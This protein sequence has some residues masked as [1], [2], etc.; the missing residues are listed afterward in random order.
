MACEYNPFYIDKRVLV[1][2][3]T[4]IL[5]LHNF[6]E[7]GLLPKGGEEDEVLVKCSS[8]DYNTRW[9]DIN[10]LISTSLTFQNA[11]TPTGNVI[12]WEG[13]L[14]KDTVIS[15]ASNTY[16]INF[17]ELS[18]FNVDALS[19]TISG[20]NFLNVR[21]PDFNNINREFGLLQNL[22]TATGETEYT[23]YGFPTTAGTENQILVMNS[24]GDLE[25]RDNLLQVDNTVFVMKNGNDSTAQRE[26]FDLPFL[27]VEAAVAAANNGDTVIVYP[28]QYTEA[29]GATIMKPFISMELRPQAEIIVNE[30]TLTTFTMAGPDVSIIGAGKITMSAK[31]SYINV[32]TAAG[33]GGKITIDIDQ[34][35]L[36]GVSLNFGDYENVDIKLNELNV[37]D[38]SGLLFDGAV[39]DLSAK[40]RVNKFVTNINIITTVPIIIADQFNI[41]SSFDIEINKVECINLDGPSGFLRTVANEDTTK[42]KLHINEFLFTNPASI[43]D[44]QA[45][46]YRNGACFAQKDISIKGIRHT[47]YLS[48][49]ITLNG[50]IAEQG[51]ITFEG[52]H[53]DNAVGY[54]SFDILNLLKEDEEIHYH[55]NIHDISNTYGIA[56]NF[57]TMIN[58]ASTTGKQ[59]ISGYFK[60]DK[61][62][63][64]A[65]NPLAAIGY[66]GTNGSPI[67]TSATID[68]FTVVCGAGYPSFRRTSNDAGLSAPG[69]GI[70]NRHSM[71]NEAVD[72]V[73]SGPVF[74]IV[75]TLII[76][77]AVI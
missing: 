66:G 20:T 72:P 58:L 6:L 62:G 34:L 5:N 27:T 50:G 11:L 73:N 10:N 55:L 37:T 65:F 24:T 31:P 67:L 1:N 2:G 61:A 32:P 38:A 69:V 77:P 45:P 46:I 71:T 30:A 23:P 4:S 59:K 57:G 40:V 70:P 56:A 44:A 52:L 35:F 64:P 54:G 60:T 26:R 48:K 16:L 14:I 12:T 74:L 41:P 75:P 7:L 39:L 3:R 43:N 25:F 17:E 9:E 19:T 15:G 28:G 18:L 21:T 49:P 13:P 36:D 68:N 8:R 29:N 42:I 22:D 51:T 33:F 53:T 76:D 47:G 63:A